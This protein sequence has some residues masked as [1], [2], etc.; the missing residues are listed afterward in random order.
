MDVDAAAPLLD[1]NREEDA[2]AKLGSL[3]IWLLLRAR[4]P[5]VGATPSARGAH[6]ARGTNDIAC[7][8]AFD[9]NARERC[10]ALWRGWKELKQDKILFT[11]SFYEVLLFRAK[12]D[13]FMLFHLA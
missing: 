9:P 13:F 1:F 7:L 3:A 10:R 12:G 8:Y 5:R 11:S 6:T 4:R 2:D